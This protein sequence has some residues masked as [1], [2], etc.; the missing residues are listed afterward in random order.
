MFN[1]RKVAQMAAFLLSK[2]GNRYAHLK[3]MKLLYLAD[4][5]SMDTFGFPISGDSPFSM[6]HGPVLSKTLYL[7][8]GVVESQP[9][10]WDCWVSDKE[11]HE[12]SLRQ[13]FTRND[14]DELSDTDIDVLESVWQKF[15]HMGKWEIRDYT[16]DNCSEW[17]DPNGS[18]TPIPARRIFKALGKSDEEA[19][20]LSAHLETQGSFSRLFASL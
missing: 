8:D 6:P 20:E 18:S 14:L 16:H 2:G 19:N 3:L 9:D 11:N 12:V 4:R 5:Q 15:G 10:G 1:E 7:I 17:I 13:S